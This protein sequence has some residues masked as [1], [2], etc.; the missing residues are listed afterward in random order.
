M[1]MK[2]RTANPEFPPISLKRTLHY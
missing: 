1:T 2:H